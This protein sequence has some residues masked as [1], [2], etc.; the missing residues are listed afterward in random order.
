MPAPDPT[1]TLSVRFFLGSIAVSAFA[2]GV[3]QAGWRHKL[4]IWTLFII[5][6]VCAIAAICY[7]SLSNS[8]PT[9]AASLTNIGADARVWF[10]LVVFLALYSMVWPVRVPSRAERPAETAIG[11]VTAPVSVPTIVTPPV[12]GRPQELMNL[13]VDR[14]DVEVLQIVNDHA[15]ELLEVSGLV[16]NVRTSNDDSGTIAIDPD[17]TSPGL[18]HARVVGKDR[19]MRAVTLRKGDKIKCSG[20]ITDITKQSITLSDCEFTRF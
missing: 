8:L 19:T 10:G 12:L 18:V 2:L 1:A 16:Y 6:G 11:S 5:S 9:F 20:K 15:G 17:P 7:P 13:C 3:N 14:T 4:L